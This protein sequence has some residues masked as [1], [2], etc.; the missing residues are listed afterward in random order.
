MLSIDEAVRLVD[1]LTGYLATAQKARNEWAALPLEHRARVAE[2]S[3]WWISTDSTETER[4]YGTEF[5]DEVTRPNPED[6]LTVI[7][8]D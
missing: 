8:P 1:G 4:L 3:S 6:G 7:D 5:I 2:N